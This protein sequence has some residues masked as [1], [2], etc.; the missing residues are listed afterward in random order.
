MSVKVL[1]V[2]GLIVVMMS[3]IDMRMMRVVM[4]LDSMSLRAWVCCTTCT[5]A[6]GDVCRVWVLLMFCFFFMLV[7]MWLTMCRMMSCRI[8]RKIF[9]ITRMS[10][11]WIGR[12]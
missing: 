3:M 2:L 4:V 12:L 11:M 10:M 9:A 1:V 6:T 5:A 8:S 7:M